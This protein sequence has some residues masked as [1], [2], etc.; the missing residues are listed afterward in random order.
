M[1]GKGDWMQRLVQSL[2]LPS[3]P[4]P[5]MPLV[6]IAGDRRVLVENHEG[7]CQYGSDQICIRVKYGIVSIRGRGLELSRM[8]KELLII[9]GRIDGI[10]LNRRCKS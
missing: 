4:I 5:G 1:K 7:V 6:E 9:S 2:D 8:S 10:M 3:E